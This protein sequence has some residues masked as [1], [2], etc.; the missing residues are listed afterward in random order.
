MKK[1]QTKVE[2]CQSVQPSALL[3]V[4]ATGLLVREWRGVSDAYD[5]GGHPV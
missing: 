3:P 1:V 2:F 4:R 5:W